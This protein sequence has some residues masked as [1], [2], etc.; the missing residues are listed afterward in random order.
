MKFLINEQQNEKIVEFVLN[1]EMPKKFD[2]WKGLKVV[3]FKRMMT[4]R[5][6]L[7]K[8]EGV[9]TVDSEWAGNQWLRFNHSKEPHFGDMEYPTL[10]SEIVSVGEA[11]DVRDEISHIL[12]FTL[13]EST[14]VPSLNHIEIK[15]QYSDDTDK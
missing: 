6:K 11:D 1:K 14:F 13:S 8:L 10:L 7:V 9:L 12:T 2:W 15:L 3:D 4:L 5:P